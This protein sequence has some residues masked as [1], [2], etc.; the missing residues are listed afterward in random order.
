MGK[1]KYWNW[2]GDDP[3]PE[4]AERYYDLLEEVN[5]SFPDEMWDADKVPGVE[6]GRYWGYVSVYHIC[7]DR[8]EDIH[9]DIDKDDNGMH[10]ISLC[11]LQDN[12]A[13]NFWDFPKRVHLKYRVRYKV[14]M[15]RDFAFGILALFAG[16]KK[17]YRK[18]MAKFITEHGGKP[19]K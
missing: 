5:N 18:D 13:G 17:G 1:S 10:T 8:P 19:I 3:M 2:W 15:D 4:V 6:R 7:H 9:L 12:G 14:L 11:S 16:A